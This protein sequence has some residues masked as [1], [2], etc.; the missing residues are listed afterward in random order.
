MNIKRLN[1][2]KSSKLGINSR[3]IKDAEGDY[4]PVRFC[5]TEVELNFD[6]YLFEEDVKE[7]LGEDF[8][9]TNEF[10]NM[11]DYVENSLM[12]YV[13]EHFRKSEPS[14]YHGDSSVNVCMQIA[15]EDLLE[16]LENLGDPEDVEIRDNGDNDITLYYLNNNSDITYAIG[17]KAYY[18][19]ESK[20]SDER[21]KT[22]LSDMI[23]A[24][25][26]NL[27]VWIEKPT[28]LIIEFANKYV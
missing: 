12:K 26:M 14:Y 4:I 20:Y 5:Y 15:E 1:A 25:T 10:S 13:A 7:D 11:F 3:R 2:Y 6:E 18:E 17:D 27:D 23:T 9:W 8:E 28:E 21:M 19:L 24:F 16:G 22:I